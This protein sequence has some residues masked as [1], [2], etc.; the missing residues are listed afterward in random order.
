MRAPAEQQRDQSSA[1]GQV[2][3]ATKSP[4]DA[5][6]PGGTADHVR[7]VIR[8]AQTTCAIPGCL[9]PPKARGWCSSHYERWRNGR[10]MEGQIARFRRGPAIVRFLDKLD[11]H[12]DGC[13]LWTGATSADGY[14]EFRS[15][16]GGARR[17][18]AHRWSFEWFVGPIPGGLVLDH[19]CRVRHCVNPDHLEPVTIGENLDRGIHPQA[20]KTHCKRGHPFDAEDLAASHEALRALVDTLT[21]ERDV[22]HARFDSAWADMRR[23]VEAGPEAEAGGGSGVHAVEDV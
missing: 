5:A 8:M 23:A 4:R 11:V 22:W 21:E 19:L 14:A 17:V 3:L 20:A 15:G 10:S 12:P 6:T 16:G 1:V 2:E 7:S 18:R 13:W 9:A